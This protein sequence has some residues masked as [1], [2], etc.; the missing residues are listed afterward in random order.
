MGPGR[1]PMHILVLTDRD[2]THPQAGGTGRVLEAEV[3][4]W[5][6]WGHRVTVVTSGY[7][8]AS[9]EEREGGLTIHRSGS[10]RTAMPRTILRMRRGLVPEADVAFEVV[11][12]VFFMTPLWL[13]IPTVTFVQH[14]S[15]GAQY[16]A[17]LG[18]KG[19]LLGLLLET[20]PLR[21]LYGESRFMTISQPS[22]EALVRGGA[23]R[24]R[25]VVNHCGLEA[26]DFA[27]AARAAEPTLVYVGRLKA[28]KN[29]ET[30][31]GVVEQLPEVR[32]ELVGE[33][34][35]R[36]A[37]EREIESR[38]LG[39]RVRLRGFVPEER[40]RELLASAWANVMAS[41]AEGWGLSVTEAAACGTPS[42][43]LAVGGL[44]ESVVHEQTGLL[45]DDQADLA[46]QVRRLV[47]DDG[48]RD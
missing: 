12:G 18:R 42:V 7:P 9:K 44:R 21:M 45:A 22:A 11:N 5:L 36:P 28:Y 35:H 40:K 38:G 41:S 34:D 14:L 13:R 46:A 30:L 4:R 3:R 26:A 16:R 32:L 8:A 1:A 2:W 27:E 23:Q 15:G 10:L 20:L 6:E 29:I 37:L 33:G 19:P 47:E 43:A 25:V 31:L 48:L 39:E 24:E 17:E